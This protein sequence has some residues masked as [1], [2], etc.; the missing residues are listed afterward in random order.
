[1]WVEEAVYGEVKGGHSLRAASGNKQ[2]ALGIASRLDLPDNA[3][4][5]VS[6]SPYISG[7]SHGDRY[8]LARTFAD[9]GATRSGMVLTH[10]LIMPVAELV[11]FRNLEPLFGRLIRSI[12]QAEVPAGFN[13]DEDGEKPEDSHDLICAANALTSRGSG[14][15]V[16]LGTEGFEALVTSLWA[17][18]WPEARATFGFRLSFGPADVVESPTPALVCTPV[19]LSAR[20]SRYRVLNDADGRN[21]ASTSAGL[22]AGAVD[23]TPLLTFAREIGANLRDFA[24]LRLLERAHMLISRNG[25]FDDVLTTVRLVERLSPDPSEGSDAKAAI[26]ARLAAQIASATPVQVLA[27]RNLSLSGFSETPNIWLEIERWLAAQQF[28]PAD[29]ASMTSMIASAVSDGAAVGT[30]RIAIARGMATAARVDAPGLPR[31]VW[32]WIRAHPDLLDATFGL[33]PTERP[34]ELR[35][36]SQTPKRMAT[37][38]ADS[39]LQWSRVRQWL[40]LHGAVLSAI[41]DPIEAARR[42]IAVDGNAGDA[43]GIRFALRSATPAQLL[44]CAVQLGDVRLVD[45]AADAVVADPSIFAGSHCSE[46]GEQ[47][48][49]EAALRRD[50][51]VWEAPHDPFAA[52]DAVLKPIVEG[53]VVHTPLV[54]ALARTPLADLC[55]FPRREHLWTAPGASFDREYLQATA[56]GWLRRAALGNVPFPPDAAL[57]S[58]ILS[59]TALDATLSDLATEIAAGIR[60]VEALEGFDEQRFLIWFRILLSRG[61]SLPIGGS[62]ALGRLVLARTWHRAVDEMV[63]RYR[64]RRS[65]LKP[66]LRICSSMLGFFDRWM[67][68]LSAPTASEKWESFASVAAELYPSGPDHDELWSRAGGKNSDLP[69]NGSGR[70]VWRTVI[71]QIRNG[72]GPSPTRLLREMQQDYRSNEELRVLANDRDIAGHRR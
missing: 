70:S 38:L 7:F 13:L 23:P 1:M 5:G 31:A 19:A 49:W 46:F 11:Q 2:F 44:E 24:D 52:R 69:K 65:D 55:D 42:Q 20:W 28:E 30:W 35:V 72:R 67:L 58:A 59:G 34:V 47:L 27:M 25:G 45:L 60:I 54:E 21:P 8:V 32:R 66:A 43:A 48:V 40:A 53:G 3:P 71:G 64:G 14:P 17:N 10:A 62:E 57:T 50:G 6:W 26:A 41:D 9:V 22:L 51:K 4:P 15:V 36:A 39:V 33:L 61:G 68:D 37:P 16:R 63:G 56:A 29:D 12:D 18:I